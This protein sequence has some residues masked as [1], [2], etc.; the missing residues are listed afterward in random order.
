MYL[1]RSISDGTIQTIIVESAVLNTGNPHES[2]HPLSTQG[3]LMLSSL[4]PG[5]VLRLNCVTLPEWDQ[6]IAGFHRA[7]KRWWDK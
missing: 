4:L 3:Y 2:P 7:P 1:Q 6:L 5:F